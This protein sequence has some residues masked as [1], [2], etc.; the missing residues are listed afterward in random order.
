MRL[1]SLFDRSPVCFFSLLLMTAL[2]TLH[3]TPLHKLHLLNNVQRIIPR[4]TIRPPVN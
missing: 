2:V 4:V 1:S 3:A